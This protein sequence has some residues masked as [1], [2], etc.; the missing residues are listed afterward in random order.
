MK[1][2]KPDVLHAHYVT[3]YGFFGGFA[4]FK[5]YVITAWGNDVLNVLQNFLLGFARSF[6]AAF[7]L[8]K[9][10][11]ITAD[12]PHLVQRF[13]NLG[14][15]QQKILLI[16]FGVD[17]DKFKPNHARK[18]GATV[19]ST[20]RL[21]PLYNV[22]S[23]IEAIPQ[24]VKQVPEAKFVV[25]N[26]G[27]QE[28]CLKQRIKNLGLSDRV[29]FIGQV[30]NNDMPNIL[31]QADVYV[32]TSLSDGG[33]AMSTAEAMACELP[34]IITD[35]SCNSQWIKDGMLVPNNDVEALSKAIVTTL[36]T[37]EAQP[38]YGQANRTFVMQHDNYQKEMLEM[39]KTYYDLQRFTAPNA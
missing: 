16:N 20:R 32:S 7:V 24:V 38:S 22:R 31:N 1:Q 3:N 8:K 28:H 12:A 27:S 21:E 25:V 5:P 4:N 18:Q 2:I 26:T 14:F 34:I 9:A 23:F 15:N 35:N 33:I 29:R 19:I 11:L 30:S 39:E 6:M 36:Q 13:I 10:D 17:T 37:L